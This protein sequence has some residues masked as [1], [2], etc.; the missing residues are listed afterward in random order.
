LGHSATTELP[1]RYQPLWVDA[2]RRS[3]VE[4]RT[5]ESGTMLL[6]L[7][8]RFLKHLAHVQV[9][10]R[11]FA[12]AAR[13]S[14]PDSGRRT[15]R[16]IERERQRLGRELH[17]NVG[18]LLAAIRVQIEAVD[19]QLPAAPQPVREAV[20]KISMLATTALE[21]VRD[22]SRRIHP[23]E[24]QRLRLEDAL[25]QLW[26]LTG[27]ERIAETSVTIQ[28]LEHDPGVEI[29]SLLF[30]AAQEGIAN[31]LRHARA[32]RVELALSF[33]E[34][35][36][37]LRILDDGAGFDARKVLAAPANLA[38]GIGLRSIREQT[39]ELNGKLSITSGPPGTTLELSVPWT[40][41]TA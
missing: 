20:E 9:L 41:G 15:I 29:K 21:Q 39:A 30:R 40:P 31:V 19:S 13:R 11:R 37:C 34:N 8:Q 36:L 33:Q 16:Q 23:P 35:V 5:I 17:T 26:D 6:Q 22:I 2:Y 18:Q 32:G 4:T 14:R 27:V 10:E 24:W 12:A 28:P 3:S 1:G 7:A 25:R 38:S